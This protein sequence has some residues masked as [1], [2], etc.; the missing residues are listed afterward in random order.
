VTFLVSLLSFMILF[1]WYAA[2]TEW[3]V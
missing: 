1:V 2:N 3:L